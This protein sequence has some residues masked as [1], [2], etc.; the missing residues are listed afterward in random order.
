M[1]TLSA[2]LVLCAGNSPVTGEFPSQRPV[3][4]SFDV[5]FDLRL[6]KRLSKQ[7]WWLESPSCSLW[8]HCNA[9]TG[10]HIDPTTITMLIWK[11]GEELILTAAESMWTEFVSGII[12]LYIIHVLRMKSPQLNKPRAVKYYETLAY[13]FAMRK[14]RC[15][16]KWDLE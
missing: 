5:F 13:I 11:P 1:E 10:E 7:S 16:L 9:W 2:L 4:R 14:I 8:Y 12:L 3:T 6:N 15:K